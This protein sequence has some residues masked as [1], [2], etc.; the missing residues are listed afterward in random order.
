MH[1]HYRNK[2]NKQKEWQMAREKIMY[3]TQNHNS[4]SHTKADFT[5]QEQDL[6]DDLVTFLIN[7]K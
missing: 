7:L 4:T 6:N 2:T 5:L 3:K 1:F